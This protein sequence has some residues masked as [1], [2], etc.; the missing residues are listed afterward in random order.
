MAEGTVSKV[1]KG[2]VG[3]TED[4]MEAGIPL[5]KLLQWSW[6][7]VVR[8]GTKAMTGWHRGDTFKKYLGR[9]IG[10]TWRLTEK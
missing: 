4:K 7:M 6:Q 8:H 9:K 2:C 5:R 10:R 1:M 3:E